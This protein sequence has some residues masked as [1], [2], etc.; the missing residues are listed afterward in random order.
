MPMFVVERYLPA[1]TPD[2][3]RDQARREADAVGSGPAGVR[4][5]RTTYLCGDELCFSMFEAPSLDALL[6]ANARG[7]MPYE[8]IT[9]AIDITDEALAQGGVG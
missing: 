7:G 4:H 6:F 3:V 9:E 1:L 2:A 5:V 8:R